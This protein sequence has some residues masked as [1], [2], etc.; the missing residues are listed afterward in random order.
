MLLV[1]IFASLRDESNIFYAN[2]S[3]V[4]YRWLEFNLGVNFYYLAT[5]NEPFTMTLMIFT[6]R[7]KYVIIA[8]YVCVW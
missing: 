7:I 5:I 6:E 8:V 4:S 1:S 3:A 2:A